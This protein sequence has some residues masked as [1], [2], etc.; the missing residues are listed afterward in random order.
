MRRSFSLT[1]VLIV[2][3][4]FG[5]VF[6]YFIAPRVAVPFFDGSPASAAYASAPVSVADLYA[7]YDAVTSSKK[8]RVLIVPG[9]EP[10]SGGAEFHG[11][12]E[13]DMVVEIAQYLQR[14][15]DT[16]GNYTTIMTRD[17]FAWNPIFARYFTENKDAIEVWDAAARQSAASLGLDTLPLVDHLSAPTNVALRLYGITKWADENA[18]DITLHLHFNDHDRPRLSAP[19][20][21]SGVAIYVPAQQYDNSATSKAVAT[22]ILRRLSM[23]NP[24]SNL[25][26]E[27]G[28]VIE[29]PQLIAVG[30]HNTA[31]S[32]TMLIEYDYIYQPQFA[33]AKVRSLALQDLAYQTYLG[34]QDFFTRHAS[35]TSTDSYDP[36]TLYAW[37][38]P[39]AGVDADP[40]DT[41]ALQTALLM[42]GDFPPAGKSLHSCPHSG[43]FGACTRAAIVTFQKKNAI[44]N[45]NGVGA[46]TFALL[47]KI[48]WKE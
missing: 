33:N 43:A 2:S 25:P 14:Y 7:N 38:T 11:A 3:S 34:V 15:M 28:G 48:Y 19:G 13:H 1:T 39:V 31:G 37:R 46:K 35:T 18:I 24:V 23:Y 40:K 8:T 17:A 27:S 9:H 42:D 6:F 36:S 4:A 10:G 30:A 22:S 29:D 44:E 5:Y 32:A 47:Q 26:E 16:Q 20:P 45:E 21:Y 41:Y 12:K